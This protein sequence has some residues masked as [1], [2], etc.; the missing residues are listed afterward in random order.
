MAPIETQPSREEPV[1]LSLRERIIQARLQKAAAREAA[2]EAVSAQSLQTPTS[3]VVSGSKLDTRHGPTT[4][5]HSASPVPPDVHI[6]VSESLTEQIVNAGNERLRSLVEKLISQCP[7]AKELAVSFFHENGSGDDESEEDE[8]TGDLIDEEDDQ[9]KEDHADLSRIGF[10]SRG[11]SLLTFE[12]AEEPQE[13]EDHDEPD[14]HSNRLSPQISHT[15]RDLGHVSD[16]DQSTSG[17][18]TE[19]PG[20]VQTS[21]TSKEQSADHENAGLESFSGVDNS[22]SINTAKD[23]GTT[24]ISADNEAISEHPAGKAQVPHTASDGYSR[25]DGPSASVTTTSLKDDETTFSSL[26]FSHKPSESRAVLKEV[27]NECEGSVDKG[28]LLKVYATSRFAFTLA[29]PGNFPYDVISNRNIDEPKNTENERDSNISEQRILPYR[30]ITRE[31]AQEHDSNLLQDAPVNRLTNSKSYLEDPKV[32]DAINEHNTPI[33]ASSFESCTNIDTEHM[34]EG[35]VGNDTAVDHVSST[36]EEEFESEHIISSHYLC[37]SCRKPCALPQGYAINAANPLAITCLYCTARAA[38]QQATGRPAVRSRT[39]GSSRGESP[40]FSRFSTPLPSAHSS[41]ESLS[42]LGTPAQ[43]TQDAENSIMTADIDEA[44]QPPR[45][46]SA[47]PKT[48]DQEE[49]NQL[50]GDMTIETYVTG[51]Q[52]VN[53]SSTDIKSAED[54]QFNERDKDTIVV[55]VPPYFD[56]EPPTSHWRKR[57]KHADL[58]NNGGSEDINSSPMPAKRRRGRPLKNFHVEIE[59]LPHQVTSSPLPKPKSK[60]GRPLG[61]KNRPKSE[62][63][64]DQ[65]RSDIST[66]GRAADTQSRRSTSPMFEKEMSEGIALASTAPQFPR[67]TPLEHRRSATPSNQTFPE[68]AVYSADEAEYTTLRQSEQ[69]QRRDYEYITATAGL[70]NQ[71]LNEIPVVEKNLQAQLS[72]KVRSSPHIHARIRRPFELDSLTGSPKPNNYVS[73]TSNSNDASTAIP[74]PVSEP[75]LPPAPILPPVSVHRQELLCVPRRSSPILPP[76]SIRR[77]ELINPRRPS[78]PILPPASRHR[79]PPLPPPTSSRA[80][81]SHFSAT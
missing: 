76:A 42:P 20:I 71:S 11:S 6:E 59:L 62:T 65:V 78:S 36:D 67:M 75:I 16:A 15:S 32:V 53:E 30:E 47:P 25:D 61:S 24:Q 19:D 80:S 66:D 38:Y 40:A 50:Q 43:S 12:A 34:D 74:T 52:L 13:H 51:D 73:E 79:P 8:E 55:E 4:A 14:R 70:N 60:R 49:H 18:T 77:Q 2:R 31:E 9:R 81:A 63:W 46:V 69:G 37:E 57:R 26:R 54:R 7:G 23:I 27:E 64:V 21:T 29:G 1:H 72:L 10:S 41:G 5:S 48:V 58:K 33:P 45:S 17:I 3:P 39:G 28:D 35:Q 22:T 44:T 68:L 56:S